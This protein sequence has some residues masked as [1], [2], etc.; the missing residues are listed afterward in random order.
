MSRKVRDL[1]G[2]TFG[3]LTVI[4]Q[5]EKR[6]N[7][8]IAWECLC[9]CGNQKIC[10]S[11]HLTSNR[12]VSCGCVRNNLAKERASI[13]DGGIHKRYE[14]TSIVSMC[15]KLNKNSS[16]G[17]KGVY[18]DSLKNKYLAHIGFKGKV[19]RLGWFDSLAEASKVRNIAEEHYFEPMVRRYADS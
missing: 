2:Y 11:D 10:R 6:L 5:H 4:R 17:V 19:I 14:G 3:M 12:V 9:S 1:S 8:N 7:K 16:T 18:Y 13:M 15:R